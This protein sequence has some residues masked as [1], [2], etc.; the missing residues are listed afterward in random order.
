MQEAMF[1]PVNPFQQR[2]PESFEY[3]EQILPQK[4]DQSDFDVLKMYAN[5]D[6][7]E[8]DL[9][10]R[11]ILL[12]SFNS[13]MQTMEAPERI[14]WMERFLTA[15]LP[16][17][18]EAMA[19]LARMSKVERAKIGLFIAKVL[20]DDKYVRVFHYCYADIYDYS[21]DIQHDWEK[22]R[23]QFPDSTKAEKRYGKIR[24]IL[25]ELTDYFIKEEPE[26][27]HF[28]APFV[29][30][31][32]L[33]V[34]PRLTKTGQMTAGTKHEYRSVKK[35][36][37]DLDL[38]P[39]ELRELKAKF[40]DKKM[41]PEVFLAKYYGNFEKSKFLFELLLDET[42][43]QTGDLHDGARLI[44]LQKY[45][46]W[47]LKNHAHF[48]LPYLPRLIELKIIDPEELH[49][50]LEMVRFFNAD[51]FYRSEEESCGYKKL[52]AIAKR[53]DEN[54][55]DSI[56][57]VLSDMPD[58]YEEY[59][60]IQDSSRARATEHIVQNFS[61]IQ[62]HF[63]LKIQIKFLTNLIEVGFPV[64]TY[65]NNK[66]SGADF[67][68]QL[69]KRLNELNERVFLASNLSDMKALIDAGFEPEVMQILMTD[70][71]SYKNEDP[72]L[73]RM[74]ANANVV[75]DWFTPENKEKL[76]NL[77]KF[78]AASVWTDDAKRINYAVDNNLFTVGELAEKA[79]EKEYILLTNYGVITKKA[80]EAESAGLDSHFDAKKYKEMVQGMMLSNP[81]QILYYSKTADLVFD[82]AEQERIIRESLHN[83]QNPD[84]INALM[85]QMNKKH[86]PEKYRKEIRQILEADKHAF[87][88]F[89]ERDFSGYSLIYT[90]VEFK[91]LIIQNVDRLTMDNQWATEKIILLFIESEKDLNKF[92]SAIAKR[93]SD[94]LLLFI[95]STIETI[96][97][98]NK[99][100]VK[101]KWHDDQ[102]HRQYIL[103]KHEVKLL[104]FANGELSVAARNRCADNPK[105]LVSSQG[106][107]VKALQ[108][109]PIL[110]DVI[111]DALATNP[112]I[113]NDLLNRF[114]GSVKMRH[115]SWTKE[116]Y[117]DQLE[118]H[119]IKHLR[120]IAFT[121]TGRNRYRFLKSVMSDDCITQI[122]KMNPMAEAQDRLTLEK[123]FYRY[124]LDLM[125]GGLFFE[126]YRKRLNQIADKENELNG[127]RM[128]AGY[129]GMN[130]EF[131]KLCIECSL[132]GACPLVRKNQSAILNLDAQQ[133][134]TMLPLLAF[135]SY[136]E[137][138]KELDFDL[139]TDDPE[140]VMQRISICIMDYLK[141]VF[142]IED[143]ESDELKVSESEKSKKNGVALQRNRQSFDSRN[144]VSNM[145]AIQAIIVYFTGRCKKD[146]DMAKAVT[147]YVHRLLQGN[148]EEWRN[149]DGLAP[150]N[151]TEKE[152]RIKSLQKQG[153]VP[154]NMTLPQYEVW[155]TDQEIELN[156]V[157][158]YDMDDIRLGVKAIL[159]QAVADAHVKKEDVE[160]PFD[161]VVLDYEKAILP[162]TTLNTR[163]KEIGRKMEKQKKEVKND[164]NARFVAD[165]ELREFEELREDL[166][167][168]LEENQRKIDK[169]KAYIYLY[170]LRDLTAEE[171]QSK[172]IIYKKTKIPFKQVFKLLEDVYG[173]EHPDFGGDLQRLKE[174]V[175]EGFEKVY[176]KSKIAKAEL[177]ITDKFDATR[178]IRIGSEP[179]PSCQNFDSDSSLN[180][181][182][183]SYSVDPNVRMIQIYDEA[184]KIIS[185][186]AMRLLADPHGKP[187]LFLERV[188]ST[189]AHI[190]INEAIIKFASQ[191]AKQMGV[192]LYSHSLEGMEAVDKGIKNMDLFS[193]NSR[194]PYVYTDAGGGRIRDGK[195]K[196][197]S[198]V[199]IG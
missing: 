145:E 132:L 143:K 179:V 141:K 81:L 138:D 11:E 67:V 64:F 175:F 26:H 37:S 163:I 28:I 136:Y 44:Y 183:L 1:Q 50:I 137:L 112:A 165:D 16:A 124:V 149:W 177:T 24:S 131:A 115:N 148:F 54:S 80:Q 22:S 123:D 197:I 184:G 166:K 27:F 65:L 59:L 55:M 160:R 116:G 46:Q 153:L 162:I 3:E 102:Y 75:F 100:A 110:D 4:N 142:E 151:D 49:E 95:L 169:I 47:Y 84:L 6:L 40:N 60:S 118:K 79:T 93:A 68:R 195:Y 71:V 9:K 146:D 198:A 125:E 70:I 30:G 192:G 25:D 185:R 69:L 119:I 196:I 8:L 63:D 19:L 92:L 104:A 135:I 178:Y 161:S 130:H 99:N 172:S 74:T 82:L 12:K 42:T 32:K 90:K 127:P 53:K 77:I 106:L 199:K 108:N 147:N 129:S 188:Y 10:T 122:Y 91:E 2:K 105:L 109:V 62:R 120:I 157:L 121:Q 170:R 173:N 34:Q 43:A 23:F 18:E 57:Y 159:Q 21:F 20:L 113:L 155:T 89:V 182:L 139:E 103:K 150:E 171:L 98:K 114:R 15:R 158:Q 56:S 154:E 86:K 94:S 96:Q 39:H 187:Q 14:E 87:G 168:Y 31:T 58:A 174:T 85:R 126:L 72:V 51:A 144:I 152:E 7:M 66:E 97:D 35:E 33:S 140:E 52:E 128:D 181:G 48:L 117:K 194:A 107:G 134:K 45:Y 191:K 180:Y 17:D 101:N 13:T 176:G 29:D 193:R 83:G 133:R 78:Q 36:N 111:D 88:L 164:P 186:A 167:N 76:L 156:E 5:R 190:K 38:P 61:F 73:K 189:N 41:K